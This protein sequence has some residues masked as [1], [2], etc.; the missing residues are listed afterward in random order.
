MF[1]LRNVNSR[2]TMTSLSVRR[3]QHY[4]MIR[5][6]GQRHKVSSN[7]RQYGG[8]EREKKPTMETHV[9][10]H[11]T[12]S[13]KTIFKVFLDMCKLQHTEAS[14][15]VHSSLVLSTHLSE[16]LCQHSAASPQCKHAHQR[17]RVS[18][19]TG[20]GK[21]LLYISFYL[22]CLGTQHYVLLFFCYNT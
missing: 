7:K 14:T 17:T 13:H 12:L 1:I 22:Q 18:A 4:H 9:R 15:L 5:S 20:T 8:Q 19:F 21:T 11:S 10:Q 2:K 16:P 3:V 6:K